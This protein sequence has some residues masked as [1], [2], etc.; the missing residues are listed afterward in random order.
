ML[1]LRFVWGGA[2]AIWAGYIE[3][4]LRGLGVFL[5]GDGGKR[6]EELVGDIGEDSGAAGGD[7]VLREEEEQAREEVVD[8]GGGGEI[9]EI[10]G[11]GGGD[12]RGVGLWRKDNL[13]VFRAERLG[14]EA[15]EAAAHAVREAIAAA[16]RVMH[17]AG[18]SELRSHWW[19]PFEWGSTPP[20]IC[21][22]DKTK[23]LLEKGF[24]S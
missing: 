1:L 8:L 19:F 22:D 15:D 6:A 14:T 2:V 20:A 12:F 17:R 11:E 9:V 4:D 18:S 7:F 16:V 3:D 24:V 23:E 10:D 5:F 13:I 21:I